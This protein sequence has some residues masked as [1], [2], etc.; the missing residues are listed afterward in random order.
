MKV[1]MM[2]PSFN[3]EMSAGNHLAQDLVVDLQKAGNDVILITPVSEKYAG[4]PDGYHDPCVVHRIRSKIKGQS[5]IRRIIRYIDTS[6]SMYKDAKK[7]ECDIILSHSMPPLLGPLSCILGK[8][9]KKAV[10]YWEQDIVSNSIISTG[11][12]SENSLKQKLMYNVAKALEKYTEKHCTHIV[13]ISQQLKKM[14]VDRGINPKKITVLYN[15]IDTT[16]IFPKIREDNPLFE[17]LGLSREDFIVSYC[18]NLGVPQNVEIM[19]D[20]AEKLK[21]VVGL[22]FLL[23]GNGSRENYIKDYLAKKNLSNL[24]YH[25]LYPLAQACDVY[26][27]GDIGLV[28]GKKGTSGNGFPSKMWSILAA[29][30]TMISCFDMESELSEFVRAGNCGISIEPDSAEKL[31]EAIM[32]LFKDR[33]RCKQ[34]AENART[35]AVQY[36]ERKNATKQ[37][38]NVVQREGG[39]V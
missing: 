37:F 4:L 29:G 9:M 5:I 27:V 17:D 36:A 10:I 15:W 14:H 6:F 13:T 25:P 23:I 20:A 35:F 32:I 21:D 33:D 34:C 26:N 24:V 1:L 7:V 18:G 16:Q 22:K 12:G 38:V 39:I 19:I 31:A 28:I 8:K 30:Q 2:R 11:V 3:P